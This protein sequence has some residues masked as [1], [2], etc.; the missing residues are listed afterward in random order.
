MVLAV[1]FATTFVTGIFSHYAQA[2]PAPAWVPARPVWIYR[3]TQAVHVL[4]GTAAIPC[5]W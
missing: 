3:V 4:A 2:E 5:C 1:A